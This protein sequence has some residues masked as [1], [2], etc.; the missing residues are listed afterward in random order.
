MSG[1]ATAD[2]LVLISLTTAELQAVCDFFLDGGVVGEA[3]ESA[4]DSGRRKL[5]AALEAS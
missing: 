2:P 4:L 3:A 5:E 1:L